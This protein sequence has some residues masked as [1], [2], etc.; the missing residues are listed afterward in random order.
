M[1]V[2]GRIWC[3]PCLKWCCITSLSGGCP[4]AARRQDWQCGCRQRRPVVRSDRC[5]IMN[6][7]PA[8]RVKAGAAVDYQIIKCT[9]ASPIIDIVII[10]IVI[11]VIIKWPLRCIDFCG[12][13]VDDHKSDGA[14]Q[15]WH[16]LQRILSMFRET[17]T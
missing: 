7:A 16:L 17:L 6:T 3:P 12:F 5:I 2:V 13:G 4:A 8:H 9:V 1:T 11:I 14:A 10:A 15:T